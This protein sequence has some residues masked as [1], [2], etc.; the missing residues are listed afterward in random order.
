MFKNKTVFVLGAGASREVGLPTG[1]ELK[2]NVSGLL[3]IRYEDGYQRISG[4][5]VIDS[6]LR[7]H[8]NR[9]K[10]ASINRYLYSAWDIRDAMPMAVSIDNYIEA[11]AADESISLLG[12]LAIVRSILAAEKGSLLTVEN[13]QGRQQ[14][15]YGPLIDT[16]FA[17]F[18][19]KLTEGKDKNSMD[20]MFENVTFI[21]FNYDR[22]LQQF[23]F[24]ALQV[25]YRLEFAE[26]RSVVENLRVFFPYGNVGELEL[27]QYNT[28]FGI[29]PNSRHLH[30][31]AQR[32][33]TFSEQVDDEAMISA[34][35]DQIRDARTIVFLGFAFHQQNVELIRPSGIGNVERVFATA[36]GMSKSSCI[37]IEHRIRYLLH[38]K[39]KEVEIHL[40]NDLKAGQLFNEFG[41]VL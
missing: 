28:G 7:D 14:L 20:T 16:W 6:A 38:D 31:M 39:N 41:L 1:D 15:S 13:N 35:R 33:K 40:R 5:Q 27:E 22:C 23:L 37:E 8:I 18:I 9:T 24:Y 10:E 2:S 3:D 12:K 17:Q 19:K 32:I 34:F 29:E 21:S 11:H 30:D 26:A 36:Y 4:D 25:Y